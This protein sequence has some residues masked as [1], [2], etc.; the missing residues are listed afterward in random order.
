MSIPILRRLL[1]FILPYKWIFISLVGLILLSALLSPILPLLVQRTIDSVIETRSLNELYVG[2]LWMVGL[3]GIQSLIG[4]FS[5]MLSGKISQTIIHDIRMKVYEKIIRLRLTYYDQTQIGRLVTR[6]VSDVENLSDVFSSGFAAILGDFLQLILIVGMMFY[7]NV[8]LTLICLCTIPPLLISTYVFKEKVKKSF[9]EVRAAVANMNAFVQERIS[10]MALVQILHVED[11]E[12][13]KFKEL[14]KVHRDANIRSILYYSVYF[15]VADVIAAISTGLIVWYGTKG[16]LNNEF[17]IG[18]I[19]AFIMYMNQFFR[20]IRQ[21]ADRINTLQMGVVGVSRIFEILDEKLE[22]PNS[23][24]SDK[25]IEGNIEFKDVH[26]SYVPDQPVLKGINISIKKG[27]K[28]AI[29]GS[30]G[31]G[32]SSIVNLLNKFYPFQKG[33][34]EIDGLDL[35]EYTIAD[36]RSQIGLVLQDVFLFEGTIYDNIRMGN[37]K[38]TDDEIEMAARTIG[39]HEFI[40]SL[41]N[42]YNY[43]VNERGSTL[44]VGQRQLLSFVRVMMQNANILVL[45]EAT[46]SIDSE[47]EQLIQRAMDNIMKNKTA[48]IIAHRLSTIQ[49]ADRILVLDKGEIIESGTHT[50]LL[51]QN[52]HY[53]NLYKSQI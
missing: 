34:I 46:A 33:V 22:E 8:K 53:S 2:F 9:G 32:K 10:G 3:L 48:I 42:N 41:P 27:E 12:L 35:Q 51:A 5:T 21:I 15:P 45:D 30:T 26:F 17:S 23:K 13:E 11:R 36:L 37:N 52:S 50:E 6:T 47:N 31:A 14:N 16:V 20:P 43:N 39:I 18:L 29:V 7:L 40:M 44:S 4:Y 49:K 25:V 19:S 24:P 28:I 38:I 1:E